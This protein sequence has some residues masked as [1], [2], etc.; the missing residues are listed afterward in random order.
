VRHTGSSAAPSC[1]RASLA[2]QSQLCSPPDALP[3]GPRGRHAPNTPPPNTRPPPRADDAVRAHHLA[4]GRG[5]G[6]RHLLHAGRRDGGAGGPAVR[7]RHHPGAGRRWGGAGGAGVPCSSWSQGHRVT[8]SQGHKT[9]GCHPACVCCCC[10]VG[11]HTH[12]L[13]AMAA[14]CTA[15]RWPR[16]SLTCAWAT[17]CACLAC[18]ATCPT[19]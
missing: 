2:L 19:S 9:R 1:T 8:G 10:C 4:R 5:H 15:C 17:M 14:S 16:S 12:S 7:E 11:R 18:C 6:R 13:N 3:S